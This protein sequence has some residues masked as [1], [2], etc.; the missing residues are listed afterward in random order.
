MS[1]TMMLRPPIVW[2]SHFRHW[3][4]SPE[5]DFVIWMWHG[6]GNGPEWWIAETANEVSAKQ[7]F[8]DGWRYHAPAMPPDNTCDELT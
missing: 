8:A 4:K 7:A 1:T 6:E 3:I 5:G 2:R